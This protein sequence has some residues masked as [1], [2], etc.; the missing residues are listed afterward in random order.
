MCAVSTQ[1]GKTVDTE[2]VWHDVPGHEGR[3]QV[4][5][6]GEMRSVTRYV[7]WN[8]PGG[9][10]LAKGRI[11]KQRVNNVGYRVLKTSDAKGKQVTLLVHRVLCLTFIPNPQ[12]KQFVNHIDGDRLNNSLDNLEWCTPSENI[13]HAHDAG[14]FPPSHIG[15]GEKCPRARLKNAD[16]LDI[17]RRLGDGE[18]IAA[19]AAEYGVGKSTISNI[20]QKNTWVHI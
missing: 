12:G 3:L 16:V 7:N 17:R 1:E 20:K 4:C 11:L 15:K 10:R 6:S 19:L 2:L 13:Q 5:R 14:R 8:G 9:K 18:T